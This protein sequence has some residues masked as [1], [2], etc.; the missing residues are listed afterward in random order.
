[1]DLKNGDFLKIRTTRDFCAGDEVT[2]AIKPE[3]LELLEVSDDH[4][5]G[6]CS[7][8]DASVLSRSYLG[9]RWQYQLDIGGV[10]ARAEWAEP[11][12]GDKLVVRL[13][14]EDSI[15]F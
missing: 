8:L 5:E 9:A 6:E 13:P 2:I 14:P 12:A 3:N 15:V 7:R 4:P 11:I 10:P 1:M